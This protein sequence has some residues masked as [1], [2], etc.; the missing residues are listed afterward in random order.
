MVAHNPL[1]GSGRAVLPHPALASGDNAKAAQRI[2]MMNVR[3]GQPAVSNPQHPV[4]QHAAILAAPRQRAM[5]EADQLEPKHIQRREVHRDPVISIVSRDHRAQPLLARSATP[6][7]NPTL[8][9]C[10]CVGV[11]SL[12]TASRVVRSADMGLYVLSMR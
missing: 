8:S 12:L 3:D 2:W 11:P 6:L 10:L 7:G 5:P 1:D 9:E 4:P